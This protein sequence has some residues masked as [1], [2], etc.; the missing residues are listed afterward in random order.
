MSSP[1][2]GGNTRWIL[3]NPWVTANKEKGGL[4]QDRY[5]YVHPHLFFQYATLLFSSSGNLLHPLLTAIGR[6]YYINKEEDG[7]AKYALW[8]DGNMVKVQKYVEKKNE[9]KG[10]VEKKSDEHNS[11]QN[12]PNIQ[13]RIVKPEMS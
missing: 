5:L 12:D 6:F 7:E 10:D 4:V 9:A 11:D 8:S 1:K 2:L 3:E 13:W